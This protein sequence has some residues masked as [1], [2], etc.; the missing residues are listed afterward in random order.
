MN[1]LYETKIT[2]KDSAN[3]LRQR[4]AAYDITGTDDLTLEELRGLV[5]LYA[6]QIWTEC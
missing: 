6:E 1:D 2:E 4:L 5:Y 3:F